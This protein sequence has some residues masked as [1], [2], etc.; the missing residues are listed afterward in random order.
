ME[1]SIMTRTLTA[2]LL[3]FTLCIGHQAAA[4]PGKEKMQL[5]MIFNFNGQIWSHRWSGDGQHEFLPGGDTDLQTWQEMIT[6]LVFEEVDT[7]EAL[8]RVA[9]NTLG[10]YSDSGTLLRAEV[11]QRAETSDPEYLLVAVLAVNGV[12]E[13]V[14]NH[15][16]MVDGVGA[17]TVYSHRFYGDT[18]S[19]EVSAWL[20]T[21]GAHMEN[22]LLAWDGAPRPKHLSILAPTLAEH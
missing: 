8:E 21:H 9:S 5:D 17:A 13:A 15:T 19:D 6:L 4:S 20:Q 7:D 2:I 14:F 12:V 10:F 11:F 22:T 3:L 1:G 16:R 18:A